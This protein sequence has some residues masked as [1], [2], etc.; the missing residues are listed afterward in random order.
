MCFFKNLIFWK[1]CFSLILIFFLF[2]FSDFED[3]NFS[4]AVSKIK[5]KGKKNFMFTN[6]QLG[7]FGLYFEIF[8]CNK[9]MNAVNVQMQITYEPSRLDSFTRKSCYVFVGELNKR[10]LKIIDTIGRYKMYEKIEFDFSPK[11]NEYLIFYNKEINSFAV[12][13][14]DFK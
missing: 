1:R 14:I 5:L 6:S 10:K 12:K 11:V 2:S 4:G 7:E 13:T 9:K 3:C 8:N